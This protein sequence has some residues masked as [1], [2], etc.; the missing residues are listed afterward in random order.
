MF[1][2]TYRISVFAL[3]QV[4]VMLG[5]LLLPVALLAQRFGVTFPLG[6]LVERLGTAY[7]SVA[8]R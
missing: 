5:I 7:E 8:S 4:T 1:E 6:Y 3:Y 2:T